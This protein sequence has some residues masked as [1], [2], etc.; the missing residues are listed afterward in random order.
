[1]TKSKKCISEF[2][3]IQKGQLV[4][5]YLWSDKLRWKCIFVQCKALRVQTSNADCT[6][7]TKSLLEKCEKVCMIWAISGKRKKLRHWMEYC[8][9]E[10]R[11]TFSF[12][13]KNIKTCPNLAI[14]ILNWE[15]LLRGMDVEV[16]FLK[17]GY[18][19][20]KGFI[21]LG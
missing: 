8:L 11:K 3:N 12:E 2:E 6:R 10:I 18:I 15:S 21:V 13:N 20:W 1:M 4:N 17:K 7:L 9:F 16:N 5:G 19:L 14:R